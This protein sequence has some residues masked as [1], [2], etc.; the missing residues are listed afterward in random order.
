M[1]LSLLSCPLSSFTCCSA[2]PRPPS[3]LR[4]SPFRLSLL[5]PKLSEC[6]KARGGSVACCLSLYALQRSRYTFRSAFSYCFPLSCSVFHFRINFASCT[7]RKVFLGGCVVKESAHQ[8]RRC[9]FDLWVGRLSGEGNGTHS[10]HGLRIP[11]T[12]WELA[13]LTVRG[14]PSTCG[15]SP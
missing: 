13:K 7:P 11:W 2:V 9:R 12:E 5:F 3:D 1:C 8:G 10:L 4:V 14:S 6:F 15:L